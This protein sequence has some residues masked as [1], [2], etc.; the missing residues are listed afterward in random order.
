VLYHTKRKIVSADI[1]SV[2]GVKI[3]KVTLV[4]MNLPACTLC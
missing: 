2:V 1:A 4:Q 3:E